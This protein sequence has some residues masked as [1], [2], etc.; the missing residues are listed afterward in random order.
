MAGG[1]A[2]TEQAKT[3]KGK[4][5]GRR[6]PRKAGRAR[7]CRN[8][9]SSCQRGEGIKPLQRGR[10]GPVVRHAAAFNGGPSRIRNVLESE[11]DFSTTPAPCTEA[12]RSR[13]H[14]RAGMTAAAER[15]TGRLIEAAEPIARGDVAPGG[16]GDP[17]RVKL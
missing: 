6:K 11:M 14:A 3:G 12:E 16:D 9:E 7:A 10:S 15:V 2:A 4:A 5:P 17:C 13:G 1:E 8:A